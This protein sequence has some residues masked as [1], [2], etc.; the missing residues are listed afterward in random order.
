MEELSVGVGSVEGLELELGS[1]VWRV[2]CPL[3][4]SSGAVGGGARSVSGSCGPACVGGV[5]LGGSG[6]GCRHRSAMVAAC[7]ADSGAKYVWRSVSCAVAGIYPDEEITWAM[8]QPRWTWEPWGACEPAV[9]MRWAMACSSGGIGLSLV[10]LS[11]W[12]V[13]RAL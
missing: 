6:G 2:C 1:G 4:S 13:V 8:A 7:K 5:G 11:C 12:S 10:V 9:A 3:C